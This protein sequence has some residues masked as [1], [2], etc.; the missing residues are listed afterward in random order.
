MR[1]A[2]QHAH[3]V[4]PDPYDRFVERVAQVH[5]N[6]APSPC[7]RSIAGNAGPDAVVGS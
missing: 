7:D 1:V 3:L 6:D 5:E 2:E 4:V